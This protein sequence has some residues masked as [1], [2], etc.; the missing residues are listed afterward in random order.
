MGLIQQALICVFVRYFTTKDHQHLV[1][2]ASG[3]AFNAIDSWTRKTASGE[4]YGTSLA[5]L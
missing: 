5:T 2:F 4:G 1:D 3:F